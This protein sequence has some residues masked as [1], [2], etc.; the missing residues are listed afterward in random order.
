MRCIADTGPGKRGRSHRWDL[1]MVARIYISHTG[2][3]P[4]RCTACRC[5]SYMQLCPWSRRSRHLSSHHHTGTGHT[6]IALGLHTLFWMRFFIKLDLIKK[7]YQSLHIVP[8]VPVRTVKVCA[9]AVASRIFFIGVFPL[10]TLT[11]ALHTP[12]P[13]AANRLVRTWPARIFIL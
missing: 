10:G 5:L 6:C 4:S 3:C 2:M 12:P 7:P 1:H 11:E 8:A 13:V 9:F